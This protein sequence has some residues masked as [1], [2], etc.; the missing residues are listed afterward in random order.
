[1][2]VDRRPWTAVQGQARCPP[3]GSPGA[4]RESSPPNPARL[5]PMRSRRTG[6]LPAGERRAVGE[7]RVDLPALTA[8]GALHPELVLL[9][10]AAGGAALVDR[11]EAQA[12][13][14]GLL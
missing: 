8:G 7:D 10:V 6:V 3:A 9:G 12:G 4:P 2:A 1:M 14:P 5:R 13:Q 11:G